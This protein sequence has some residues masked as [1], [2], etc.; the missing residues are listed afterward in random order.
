VDHLYERFRRSGYVASSRWLDEHG[1][2]EL[3][4]A[5][6][7]RESLASPPPAMSPEELMRSLNSV[8]NTLVERRLRSDYQRALSELRSLRERSAAE[9]EASAE[10]MSSA[11]SRY[12]EARDALKALKRRGSSS[13][14]LSFSS[15]DAS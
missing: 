8:I 3:E 1:Q 5:A 6:L 9:P 14:Q 7:I 10:Q 4:V 12:A 13:A 11:L 2:A 15:G